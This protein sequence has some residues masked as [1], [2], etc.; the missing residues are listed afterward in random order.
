MD[1]SQKK[2]IRNHLLRGSPSEGAGVLEFSKQ[3][4]KSMLSCNSNLSTARYTFLGGKKVLLHYEP[5]S[6]GFKNMSFHLTPKI[7]NSWGPD[8][9]FSKIAQEQSPGK[10]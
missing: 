5:M 3:G 8:I 1:Y 7:P 4:S 9:F 6:T 2:I 10:P